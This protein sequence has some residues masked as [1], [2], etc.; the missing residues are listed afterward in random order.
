LI[1]KTPDIAILDADIIIYKAAC[2]AEAQHI[3]SED[4]LR[5]RLR[6]DLNYWTPPNLHRIILAFSCSR[7]DNFRKDFWP[8]YKENRN[9]KEKPVYLKQAKEIVS[10]LAVDEFNSRVVT[11]PRLEAD[12]LIGIGMSSNTM[13]GVSLDKD[14]RSCPGW[15]WNPE[16]TDFPTLITQNNADYWFHKQWLMGDSTDNIPGIPKVGPV[17]ASKLLD[18]CNPNSWTSLV[19]SEYSKKG[20]SYDYCL[21]QARC[22]RILR[23][24]DWDKANQTHLPWSPEKALTPESKRD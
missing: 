6:T 23:N 22:V 19:L 1:P 3:T 16:K 7:S 15:Y 20:L 9:N 12:D 2:W 10:Q 21:A 24:G 11:K 18:S 4:Q 13:I 8:K 14:I 17:K 5:D